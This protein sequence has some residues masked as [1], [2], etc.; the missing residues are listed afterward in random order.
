MTN[1]SD[2]AG[3]IDAVVF[4]VGRVLVQWDLRVLFAKLIPDTSELDWFLANVVTEDWHFQHDAGRPLDPMIAERKAQFPRYADQIDAYRARFLET[5]P[6]PVEGTHELVR[7]LQQR[8]VP[9]FAL[10]NFGAEFWDVFR[11]TEPT[12][13]LFDDILVSGREKLAKPD[14]AIYR[15]AES[16][17]GHAGER[18]FFIDDNADN[19][20]AAALAGWQ[21]HLFKDADALEA[22][23]V[24]RGLL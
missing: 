19:I 14:P 5:I 17:F 20:T 4:D 12:L 2:T 23:L 15:A 7:R 13:D 11:P 10:T 24:A 21:T 22:G 3:A 8:C 6:G 18:M 16:R 1:G 9:L